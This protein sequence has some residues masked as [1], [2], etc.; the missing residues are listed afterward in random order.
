[1]GQS[2]PKRKLQIRHWKNSRDR[3]IWVEGVGEQS[4]EHLSK[5][6]RSKPQIQPKS[7]HSSIAKDNLGFVPEGGKLRIN[8]LPNRGHRWDLIAKNRAFIPAISISQPINSWSRWRAMKLEKEL[9]KEACILPGQVRHSQAT[10]FFRKSN[11]LPTTLQW[12]PR[13]LVSPVQRKARCFWTRHST[14]PLKSNGASHVQT[15]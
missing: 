11:I 14:V 15:G 1:M 9:F 10:L 13:H 12:L 6:L 3:S 4:R 5:S 7:R 2:G 8:V